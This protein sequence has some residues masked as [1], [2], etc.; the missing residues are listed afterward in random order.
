MWKGLLTWNWQLWYKLN[1]LFGITM[2]GM[3]FIVEWENLL[4]GGA[5]YMG[6]YSLLWFM[7]IVSDNKI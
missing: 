5:I 4:L 2:L 6:T 1:T 3:G 7:S